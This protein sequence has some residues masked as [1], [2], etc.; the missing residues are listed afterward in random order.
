M[1][2]LP[3]VGCAHR[4]ARLTGELG[5]GVDFVVDAGNDRGDP[6]HMMTFTELVEVVTGNPAELLA[7]SHEVLVGALFVG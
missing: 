2:S 4:R 5:P 3:M 6:L 1:W 7:H